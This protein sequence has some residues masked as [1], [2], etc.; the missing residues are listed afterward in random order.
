MSNKIL[1]IEDNLEILDN[2]TEILELAGYEVTCASNGKEGIEKARQTKP[3]LILC[4]IMMPELDGYG[5]LR[6]LKNL[7]EFK[8]T[9]FVYMT[10]KSER[11]DFRQAMDLGADDYLTKPF[12]GD[13]LLRVA[14]SRIKK[15]RELKELITSGNGS[16]DEEMENLTITELANRFEDRQLKKLRPKEMI[17]M[18]GDTA[19]Y[20]Y[21]ITTGKIKTY[22]TNDFGK[23]YITEIFNPGDYFGHLA[24]FNN[25]T[26]QQSAMTLEQ[27]EVIFIP[28]QA[29]FRMLNA[30]NKLAVRF[31]KMLSQNMSETEDRLLGLAYNSA[32]KR[33]A[34]ALLFLYRQYNTKE[35]TGFSFPVN[36]ENLSAIAGVSPESVSRNLSDFKDERLILTDSGNI[37]ITD[38]KG[39]SGLRG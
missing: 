20:L 34:E 10:A 12:S 8:G 33:V 16:E 27:S 28:R 37:R 5:V 19:A 15:G 6:A 32:R 13:E 9:P 26:H 2:T 38:F 24:L 23:E 21:I 18:E 25:T 14:E 30:Q 1:V 31:A 7:Q 11:V 36:R 17:Y 35:D 29:F 4:D 22:K 39:L 3:D